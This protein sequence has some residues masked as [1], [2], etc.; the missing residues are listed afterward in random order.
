MDIGLPGMSGIDCI[1]RLR[2]LLPSTRILM[3]TVFEDHDRI[4]QSLKAGATGYILKK[5][6]P[7]KVLEAIQELHA[8]GAPMS[9]PIARQ[10]VAAFQDPPVNPASAAAIL[11]TREEQIL[12]LL[13][14]GYLYKQIADQL[15]ISL[16]T[17]RTHVVNI[18]GK[19]QARSRTEACL[20]AF[21]REMP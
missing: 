16:G 7:A 8:G 6:P 18:Y 20:K 19:L 13:A 12:R 5:T 2:D 14:Q 17:V 10:V 3:L 11:T 9:G 21:P 4:F 15:G 1:Q